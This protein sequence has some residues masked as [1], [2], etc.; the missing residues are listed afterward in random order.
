MIHISDSISRMQHSRWF[1]IRLSYDSTDPLA[2]TM[3]TFAPDAITWKFARDLLIDLLE[4]DQ[5]GVGD[6]RFEASNDGMS[7]IHLSS[8]DGKATLRVYTDWLDDFTIS[9]LNLMPL[10]REGAVID[11]ALSAALGG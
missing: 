7:L 11:R 3:T 6:I 1:N 4:C 2:V 10:Q 9:T 8:P 5:V